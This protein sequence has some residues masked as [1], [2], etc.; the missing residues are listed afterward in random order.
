MSRGALLLGIWCTNDRNLAEK[1]KLLCRLRLE[2]WLPVLVLAAC[3]GASGPLEQIERV[4]ADL[5]DSIWFD[6]DYNCQRLVAVHHEFEDDDPA[7]CADSPMKVDPISWMLVDPILTNFFFLLLVDRKLPG[8]DSAYAWISWS[9][10]KIDG[11]VEAIWLLLS[12]AAKFV[13]LVDEKF[14]DLVDEKFADLV[15]EKLAE[16]VDEKLEGSSPD[17]KIQS[18][19]SPRSTPIDEGLTRQMS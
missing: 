18:P 9:S 13:D 17:N 6:I 10:L 7:R 2:L 3:L 19:W 11:S 14:A 5:P 15:D 4:T 8:F 12:A 16:L 1:R